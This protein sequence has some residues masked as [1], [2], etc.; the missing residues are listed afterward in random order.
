MSTFV[1]SLHAMIVRST[2]NAFH[3]VHFD[4]LNIDSTQTDNISV[5]GIDLCCYL[6]VK[7][8]D[9]SAVA[10]LE[11]R[12]LPALQ[13]LHPTARYNQSQTLYF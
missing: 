1:T 13:L 2:S 10:M 12:G 3:H 11:L 9:G 6:H 4:A 7:A 8:D 5:A